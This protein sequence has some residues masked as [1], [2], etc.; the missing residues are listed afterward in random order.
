[1]VRARVVFTEAAAFRKLYLVLQ[2]GWRE[3]RP[4]GTVLRLELVRGKNKFQ[5]LDPSHL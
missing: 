4:D 3:E 1:M 5:S 2:K